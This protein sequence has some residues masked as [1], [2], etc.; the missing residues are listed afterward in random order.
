MQ[1]PSTSPY[2]AR[3]ALLLYLA[4][5]VLWLLAYAMHG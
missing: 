2:L 3:N 4:F 1:H 5:A